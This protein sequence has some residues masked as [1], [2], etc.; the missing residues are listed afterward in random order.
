MVHLLAMI[1]L[2]AYLHY[3]IKREPLARYSTLSLSSL[4]D[5]LGAHN[6][7]SAPVRGSRLGG[8]LRLVSWANCG[9]SFSP[10]GIA[11]D[12]YDRTAVEYVGL[13]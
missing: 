13:A 2:R 12:N 1:S 3:S 9:E 11:L 6:I 8:V 7:S 4:T 10:T 5:C